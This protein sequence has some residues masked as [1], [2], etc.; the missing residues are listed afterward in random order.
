MG[1]EIVAML[2]NGSKYN[3]ICKTLGVAKSTVAYHARKA[4]LSTGERIVQNRYDWDEI[5]RIYNGGNCIHKTSSMSGVKLSALQD[6][7]KRGAF[8]TN[9]YVECDPECND[10]VAH[11][12][13]FKRESGYD[14]CVVRKRMRR[15]NLISYSCGIQSCPLYDII[16]PEW[17]GEPVVLQLDHINGVRND[18]RLENLRWLCPNCHSQTPTYCG[19]NKKNGAPAQIR[20][21]DAR[22]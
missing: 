4:G 7:V 20:T 21:G 6:A 1:S 8:I 19:R 2:R 17:A 12:D 14:G 15:H 13:M 22:V 10:R 3:E 5:Q 11:D 18:H 16:S 9:A